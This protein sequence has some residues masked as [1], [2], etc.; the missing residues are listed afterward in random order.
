MSQLPQISEAE[1]VIM[2]ILWEDH[3]LSTNEI[4]ERAQ[5]THSWNQKT[6]QHAI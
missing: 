6:I 1:Y 2:K 5:Q 4:C 3:P